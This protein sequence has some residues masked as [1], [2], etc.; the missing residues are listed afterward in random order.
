MVFQTFLFVLRSTIAMNN[1]SKFTGINS[2]GATEGARG[3]AAAPLAAVLLRMA[4]LC[5]KCWIYMHNLQN[6]AIFFI[7]NSLL[8][9][10]LAIAQQLISD[11][12]TCFA[13]DVLDRAPLAAEAPHRDRASC[14]PYR[15]ARGALR[16]P[17]PMEASHRGAP[18]WNLAPYWKK[19]APP[20]QAP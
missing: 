14:R 17:P 6:Y 10:E 16:R 19:I 20:D 9:D 4:P 15:V 11:I 18:Y 13:A 12:L 8:G 1:W 3:G 7:G 2:G 5:T